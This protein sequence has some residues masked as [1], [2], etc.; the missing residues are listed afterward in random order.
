MKKLRASEFAGHVY[1]FWA[2]DVESILQVPGVEHLSGIAAHPE[3]AANGTWWTFQDEAEVRERHWH[4]QPGDVVFDIGPAFGSYTLTAAIQGARV[5]ACEPSLFC[6]SILAENV[7]ANESIAPNVTIIPLGVH[8]NAGWYGPNDGPRAGEMHGVKGTD[9]L[10]VTDLA[11]LIGAPE[12]LDMIK[13]DV[14]GAELGAIRGGKRILEI[15]KPRLLIEEHE[16]K[17]PG[18]G[19]ACEEIL[20]G[21]GY[22][23]PVRVNHGGVEHAFYEAPR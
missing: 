2:Y 8:E 18:I 6:R 4:F 10:E 23:V 3:G 21:L 1:R 19:A 11:T 17:Q 13:L 14:E 20:R 16:F 12:R 22:G 5:Y 7:A 15:Y 9:L